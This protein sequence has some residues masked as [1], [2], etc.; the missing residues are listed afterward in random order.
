MHVARSRAQHWYQQDSKD[1]F[2]R[3]VPDMPATYSSP[4]PASPSSSATDFSITPPLAPAAGTMHG[5]SCSLQG[6]WWTERS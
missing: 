6:R 2:E 4:K 1:P 3:T 5:Q